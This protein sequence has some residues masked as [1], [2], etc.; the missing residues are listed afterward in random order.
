MNLPYAIVATTY[1]VPTHAVVTLLQKI[2]QNSLTKCAYTGMYVYTHMHKYTYT[3]TCY[4]VVAT[5]ISSYVAT[6]SILHVSM[7][8]PYKAYMNC[9]L[10]DSA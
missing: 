5:P 4:V 7:M 10:I 2:W 9:D 1:S 6:I 3:Y 8:N